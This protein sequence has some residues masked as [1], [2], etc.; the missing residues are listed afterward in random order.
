[1]PKTRR[2]ERWISVF[3]FHFKNSPSLTKNR[4]KPIGRLKET[5]QHKTKERKNLEKHSDDLFILDFFG[6]VLV[7]IYERF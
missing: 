1:M 6:V 2:T 7:K 3:A 5:S 4:E